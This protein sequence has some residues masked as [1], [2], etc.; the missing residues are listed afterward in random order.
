MLCPLFDEIVI[1]IPGDSKAFSH[2]WTKFEILIRY[3][4]EEKTFLKLFVCVSVCSAESAK[5]R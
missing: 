1:S 3:R 5:S 2:L 4:N